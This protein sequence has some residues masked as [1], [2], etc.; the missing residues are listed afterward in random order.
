MTVVEP[1]PSKP[2]YFKISS[3]AFSFFVAGVNDG[4]LGSIIPYLM[5]SYCINTNMV[6]ILYVEQQHFEPCTDMSRYG[7]TFAGWL[8]GALSNSSVT[9]CF[10]LGSILCIGAFLQVLAHVLR[11]WFPP[12]PLFAITFFFASLGQAYND[13]HANTFVS[14]VPAAHRFLGLIHAMYMA[15]CLVG[16]LVATAV[17][18]ATSQSRW[19]LFYIF[20]LGIGVINM[21]LIVV[22]FRD[23]FAPYHLKEYRAAFS[24]INGEEHT[25]KAAW[26]EIKMT[27]STLGVWLLSLFFFF[28][29]G[30]SI[31]AG[32]MIFTPDFRKEAEKLTLAGWMVEYL[33][34]YRNGK[35]NKVGYVLTGFY[36]GSFLGRLLL[37]EP[38]YRLGERRMVFI[39]TLLCIALQL[40][41]WLYV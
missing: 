26:R 11:T 41:F 38:T 16:P 33:V 31:T 32:G 25:G 17:G 1:A 34:D 12:L 7:C 30:A 40:V 3:A 14:S 15:G 36:G 28:F 18:S 23:R 22:A 20:P 37:A 35:I 13:T 24:G 2:P 10:D 19:C 27:V 8:V 29:L 4:S 9:R 6:A 5:E 39:Y 21:V